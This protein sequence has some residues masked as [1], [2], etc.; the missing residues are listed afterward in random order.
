MSRFCGCACSLTI[1]RN[2]GI[3]PA[4]IG[5][6]LG[7]ALFCGMYYWWMFSYGEQPIPVDG[8]YFESDLSLPTTLTHRRPKD[9]HVQGGSDSAHTRTSV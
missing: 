6:M 9:E 7:G 1:L 5:N 8:V 2:T 4:A 3:I